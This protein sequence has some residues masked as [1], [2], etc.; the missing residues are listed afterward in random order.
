MKA[1]PLLEKFLPFA[2]LKNVGLRP[3][4]TARP[5]EQARNADSLP[6]PRLAESE[7]ESY[8]V[9]WGILRQG[10]IHVESTGLKLEP[11]LQ[12]QELRK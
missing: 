9:A 8:P 4:S 5:W 1:Q 10:H 11:I 2:V 3:W 12:D 7:S 6:H